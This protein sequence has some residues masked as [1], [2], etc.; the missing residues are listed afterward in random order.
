MKANHD[1]I[2]QLLLTARGQVDGL[3]KMVDDDRYCVDISNQLLA[4]TA[5]LKKANREVLKAHLEGCVQS[6]L[7]QEDGQ[8]KIQEIVNLLDKMMK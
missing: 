8:T 3:I 1:A 7:S 6:A 4:V 2:K 5:I